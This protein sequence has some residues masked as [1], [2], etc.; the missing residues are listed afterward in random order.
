MKKKL[1]KFVTNARA[2]SIDVAKLANVSQATVSRVLNHPEKVGEET[3]R[4]VYAAI[5]ELKYLPNQNARDL[6]S[7]QSK[8]ITLI[9]GP[10]EN[11]FFVDST[12][13]I[14]HYATEK[15]YKVN[16]IIADDKGIEDSYRLALSN[17]PDGLIM[18]C[19]LY[20]DTVIEHLQGLDIPFVSYNRR[21]REKLNYV[22][23]DNLAAGKKAYEYLHQQGYHSIFWVG[24]T[25]DVSTFYYRYKGFLEQHTQ[26]YSTAINR[27]LII[28]D[29]TLNYDL[30]GERI[31]QWFHHTPGKK[32]I[33][34]ATDSI[35]INL[36]D[37]TKKLGIS[38]PEEIGIIGIDNVEL[39]KHAHINLT[40]IG[41]EKNLGQ[42]AIVELIQSI[43]N[44]IKNNINITLPVEIFERGTT[45]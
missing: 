14:V 15:G 35:A 10:L 34:A 21:H 45:K 33:A 17:R 11:P 43:E 40:T 26:T 36:L 6:V 1:S 5:K 13:S 41:N 29:P 22:E 20:E 4:K 38:C 7:G 32:A 16:I 19:I 12:A 3:K 24:G 39:S 27:E 44:P 37:L 23:L 30:I 9:S 28:N 2:S 18:S 25:L 8:I 42:L 31:L